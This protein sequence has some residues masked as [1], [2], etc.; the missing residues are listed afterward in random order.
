M[1]K[2]AISKEGADSLRQLSTDMK[3][4]NNAIEDSG[5]NLIS[6]LSGQSENL[7]IFK[8]TI[9]SLFAHIVNEQSKGREAVTELTTKLENTATNIDLLVAA[10]L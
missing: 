8:D 10:G 5:K 2:V 1:S 9:E 4:I 7:G 3:K 6:S